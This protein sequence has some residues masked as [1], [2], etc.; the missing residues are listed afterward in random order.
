MALRNIANY[1]TDD[2][3]RKKS[4]VV[5]KINEKVGTLFDDMLE[6]MLQAKG[7]GLAAP[8]VGVLK[9]MVI[10]NK[11]GDFIKLIN[12]VIVEQDGEQQDFE[13]CLSI[14]GIIGEV[15]RPSRVKV[16][17]LNEKGINIEFEETDFLARAICHEIDHLNGIL[18]IDKAIP[19][20]IRNIDV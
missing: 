12:P 18:F 13:G 10:I 8:Q 5:D 14:P 6:T 4:K 3:L 1:K 9:R 20:T 11:S 7:V 16:K 17:A 15:V 2:I 19:K